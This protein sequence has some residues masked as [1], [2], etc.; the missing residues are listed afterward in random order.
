MPTAA[1]GQPVTPPQKWASATGISPLNASARI[2][3]R[4]HHLPPAFQ[5]LAPPGLP[6]P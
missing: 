5:T 2:A 3:V 6:S 1:S 4:P